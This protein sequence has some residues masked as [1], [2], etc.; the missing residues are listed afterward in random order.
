ME[1]KLRSCP[2]CGKEAKLSKS[3]QWKPSPPESRWGGYTLCDAWCVF[4][5][6]CHGKTSHKKSKEIA[7]RAWNNRNG[8]ID[9]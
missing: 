7:I 1:D 8:S 9:N 6:S 4:C 2:F 5:K 3:K